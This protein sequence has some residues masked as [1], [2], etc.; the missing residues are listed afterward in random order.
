M[1]AFHFFSFS[2]L[3]H[4]TWFIAC[5]S[6]LYVHVYASH[7][8]FLILYTSVDRWWERQCCHQDVRGCE[9]VCACTTVSHCFCGRLPFG[10]PWPRR[11][12]SAAKDSARRA[13][14]RGLDTRSR[15]S[16]PTVGSHVGETEDN[17]VLEGEEQREKKC[18]RTKAY[19]HARAQTRTHTY[20][21]THAHTV[22]VQSLITYS[23]RPECQEDQVS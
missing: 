19:T 12:R 6:V 15:R 23:F 1:A 2:S 4:V 10:C 21:H 22:R 14:H 11:G 18:Y 5:L 17:T 13:R 3:S 9:R 7:C 16:A 20:T 8:R